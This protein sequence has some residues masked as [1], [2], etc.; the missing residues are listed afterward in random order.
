MVS[1]PLEGTYPRRLDCLLRSRDVDTAPFEP[2]ALA[3][4]AQP[5]SFLG[6]SG[7]T[8]LDL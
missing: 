4:I 8:G 2:P 6:S 5:I 1:V 3:L 7:V